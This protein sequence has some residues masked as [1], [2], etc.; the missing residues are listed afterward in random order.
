MSIAR[1]PAVVLVLTTLVAC[2][3]TA[4]SGDKPGGPSMRP[5]ADVSGVPQEDVRAA[6]QANNGFAAALY[7]RLREQDGNLFFSPFSVHQALAL[8]L[9]GARGETAK[10]MQAALGLRADASRRKAALAA[11]NLS[12]LEASSGEGAELTTASALWGQEGYP[13]LDGF[14]GDARQYFGAGLETVD[15]GGAPDAAL[16]RINGWVSRQTRGRIEKILQREH[17]RPL[18]RLVLTNAIYFLGRWDSEFEKRRTRPA[19]FRLSDGTEVQAPTMHQSSDVRVIE[20]DG[21]R[22]LV[23]PYAGGRLAMVVVLPEKGRPLSW[24]EERLTPERLA[25]WTSGGSKAETAVA[26]PRFTMRFA[27]RLE[28]ALQDLGMTDAFS[29]EK[30]DFT[31]VTDHPEGLFLSDVLHKAFVRVDEKG[32]EAAAVTAVPMEGKGMPRSF[33]ADRPFLFLIRDSRTGAVLFL[34]RCADPT[35]P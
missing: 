8:A 9:A 5:T 13:F 4:Q 30:A 12:L 18:T 27:A 2:S 1:W 25:S 3:E 20:A 10:Q 14:L 24:L 21:A 17:I 11:L 35:R 6:A 23:L 28:P 26:L 29:D 33:R 34:G 15:F 22:S 7:A 16:E 19:A 31:G 32:T